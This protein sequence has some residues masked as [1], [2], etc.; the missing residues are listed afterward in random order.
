MLV[1]R[2]VCAALLVS[3][4]TGADS[5]RLLLRRSRF[6]LFDDPGAQVVRKDAVDHFDEVRH[7]DLQWT[8]RCWDSR[9]AAPPALSRRRRNASLFIMAAF[10]AMFVR[11][12]A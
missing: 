12:S 1:E 11:L 8:E 6:E 7:A 4:H 9:H 2:Q 5:A 3:I 10:G